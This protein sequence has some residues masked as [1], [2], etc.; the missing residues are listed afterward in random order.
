MST[1]T[2]SKV[3]TQEQRGRAY[4]SPPPE[5]PISE[6]LERVRARFRYGSKRAFWQKVRDG[7]DKKVSYEAVRTYHHDREPPPSYL[8]RVGEVFGVRLEWL[9]TG[10]G[11]MFAFPEAPG[12][13]KGLVETCPVVRGTSPGIQA[14]FTDLLHLYWAQAPDHAPRHSP[15]AVAEV[16]ELALDLDSLLTLPLRWWGFV[17]PEHISLSVRETYLAQFIGAL[18]AALHSGRNGNPLSVRPPR[19]MSVVKEALDDA[20]ARG[21]LPVGEDDELAGWTG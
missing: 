14:R 4:P 5:H 10:K 7:W 19:L 21:P 6:R 15:E 13:S 18:H 12:L 16:R 3:Q 11:G 20:A 8:A 17:D 9:I 1:G 2:D